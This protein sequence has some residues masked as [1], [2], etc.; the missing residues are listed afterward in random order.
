MLYEIIPNAPCSDTEKTTPNHYVDGVI[1]SAG[2]A[3]VIQAM[4][5]M[6]QMSMSEP[7]LLQYP[8]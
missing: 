4:N 5:Q 8:F 2:N 3:V 7:L 1:E 6:G